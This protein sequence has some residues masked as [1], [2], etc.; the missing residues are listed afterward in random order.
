MTM[1]A[2][3]TQALIDYL[4]ANLAGFS[5]YGG[6]NYP[7]AGWKPSDGPTAVVKVRGGPDTEARELLQPSFQVKVYGTSPKDAWTNYQA[8]DAVMVDTVADTKIQHGIME[9]LGQPLVEGE[10][11]WDYVLAYYMVLVRNI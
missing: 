6:V 10:S 3:V 8:F 7:P 1:T 9:A 11:L 5:V 4:E 2:D